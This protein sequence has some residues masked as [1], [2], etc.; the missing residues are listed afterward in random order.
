MTVLELEA[1]HFYK[2]IVN[3][4]KSRK[5]IHFNTKF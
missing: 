3:F 1:T 4:F 5:P 2:D